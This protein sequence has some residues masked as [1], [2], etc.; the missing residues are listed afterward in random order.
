MVIFLINKE[1]GIKMEKKNQKKTLAIV[2]A[3]MVAVIAVV[4]IIIAGN[5]NGWF[6]GKDNEINAQNIAGTVSV[7]R[8]NISSNLKKA[9]SLKPG[10]V[11]KTGKNSKAKIIYKTNEYIIDEKSSVKVIDIKDKK[12]NLELSKGNLFVILND[13]KAFNDIKA[14]N[15]KLTA[16]GTIF[17]VSLDK[18]S[19]TVDVYDG[20]VLVNDN[21]KIKK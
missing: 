18:A 13:G 3:I 6:G 8:D 1:K 5:V 19:V 7:K 11:I 17:S 4:A 21:V 9:S 15:Y 20:T 10:D 16:D 14:D 12:I 2:I